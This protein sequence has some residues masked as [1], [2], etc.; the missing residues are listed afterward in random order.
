MGDLYLANPV[1]RSQP[2]KNLVSGEKKCKKP[3]TRAER[4]H[5][6][7]GTW[8]WRACLSCEGMAVRG[9]VLV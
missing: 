6:G 9:G 2:G 3:I 8:R 7:R 1:G 5:E 4:G